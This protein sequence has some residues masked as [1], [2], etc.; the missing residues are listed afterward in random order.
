MADALAKLHEEMGRMKNDA[1]S[2]GDTS[3]FG[4]HMSQAESDRIRSAISSPPQVDQ[5][6]V[7]VAPYPTRTGKGYME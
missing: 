2:S 6:K 3:G 7:P 1:H 4:D 5:P